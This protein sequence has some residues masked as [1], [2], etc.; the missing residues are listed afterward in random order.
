[1]MD[2]HLIQASHRGAPVDEVMQLTEQ[3][4]SRHSGWNAKH[5]HA[6]YCKAA[7]QNHT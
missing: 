4:Q 6:W 5:F 3:Y 7:K 1:M 2:K